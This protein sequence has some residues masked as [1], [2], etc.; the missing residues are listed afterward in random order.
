MAPMNNRLLRPRQTGFT[1]RSIPGL[2]LWLDAADTQTLYTTDAGPVTA[3]SSPLE[4]S[5]CGLW[6]DASNA[7]SLTLN[8]NTVSEW[9]DLSGNARHF[10]QA[11][12]ASQPNAN[13]RTQNG[14]RVLDFA[15]A[16]VMLGN[17]ASLNIGQNIGVATMFV[18]ANS[19][20]LATGTW[21]L[22]SRNGS[23][24]Q[25]R[26][27]LSYDL[28]LNNIGSGGRRTDAD[29][30]ASAGYT[31][32]GDDLSAA[33]VHAG[34]CNFAGSDA[35]IWRN[36]ILRASNTAFHTDGNTADTNSDSVS[37][38]ALGD[39]T[40]ALD[41]VIAEVIVYPAAL[42]AAQRASVEAYLA[43]KWGISGV[44]AQ[45]TA[46][47]DPVGAWLDKSGNA[48]HAT[49]SVSASRPT[50][51][52]TKQNGRNALAF[53]GS[54]QSLSIASYNAE[55]GLS[56]LTRYIVA[57]M[58]VAQPSIIARV[59]NGGGDNMFRTVSGELRFYAGGSAYSA[60]TSTNY[61]LL[62]SGTNIIGS[63]YDGTAGS[64]AA[65]IKPYY[66][67]AAMTPSSTSGTLPTALP[68]GTPGF[69]IGSN[70]GV[71]SF[72]PG[73]IVEY[74]SYSRALGNADRQRLERYLSAKYGITLAPQVPNADA[75]DWINRVYSNGGTVSATTA[76]A[77]DTFCN[78]I[79]AAG[80]RDRFY[81][82]NLFC[83]NSDASLAAV[84]TPLFRGP[85]LTGTQYGEATDTN[86][87]FVAGDYA[88]TGAGG[89]LLG[90]GTGKYLN[91]GLSVNDIGTAASGHM[92]AYHGQSSGTNVN[93]Y[94]IGANDA[95]TT[96]MFYLGTDAFASASVVAQYGST[97]SASQTLA[98]QGH[99]PAG[100]RILSRE[101][102]SLLTHYLNG[103]VVATNSTGIA[104]SLS[105][106]AF[107]VFAANR[108]GVV[109]RL[110]NSWIAA[111]SIGLG[112]TGSQAAAYRTALQAFQT[113]LGR[114][115]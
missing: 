26:L 82:L 109:D 51:S 6:L 115:V 39:G 83:G 65:G 7:G 41:G 63:V 86:V 9:R 37:L 14:R 72:W 46:T 47:S 34:V 57:S 99:G 94:Y 24:A 75:Q 10:S 15:G 78:A 85:S 95:A 16:Q 29:S 103:S 8:G 12:P 25:A 92:S 69:W 91:T 22:A 42:T 17:A 111:Y 87:N 32:S 49:Q 23:N 55:N 108:N 81:R 106:A 13:S 31:P 110:H 21:F 80:I 19:D 97:Q 33:S 84:R 36:G 27:S 102:A 62:T 88:E 79:D 56:G 105:T 54:S 114:Q 45:A 11:T 71:N 38:G 48:R 40:N 73:R 4:I 89:G 61:A 20:A 30:F 90:N 43:A 70:I 77:V 28:G 67:G 53:N 50:I 60:V 107:A 101:S 74:I 66:N 1:P 64:V 98:T 104:T 52:A 5:G 100:H 68:G 2:A 58:S 113:A 93:R 3:V 76:T 18:V 112:F 44:H 96:N 35:F 59:W